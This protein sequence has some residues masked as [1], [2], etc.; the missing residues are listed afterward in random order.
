MLTR[1]YKFAA[2]SALCILIGCGKSNPRGQGKLQS[3]AIDGTGVTYIAYPDGI[4]LVVW[5]DF[6]S[7]AREEKQGEGPPRVKG[8]YYNVG[9]MSRGARSGQEGEKFEEEVS[10]SQIIGQ[11][12]RRLSWHWETVDGKGGTVTI[13]DKKYDP[14]DGALFLIS[15]R[16]GATQVRQLQR[17]LSA[18]KPDR[19]SFER[20]AKEDA[21]IARFVQ[22][23]AKP[24][25]RP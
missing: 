21:E 6:A 2:V 18:V 12:A 16:G 24:E 5:K 13:D 17:D 11:D 25:G 7:T 3:A 15:T 1:W 19:A 8:R 23:A 22:E 9:P 10:F 14:R 4:G 20:L